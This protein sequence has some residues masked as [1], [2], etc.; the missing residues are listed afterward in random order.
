MTFLVGVPSRLKS[1]IKLVMFLVLLGLFGS[2]TVHAIWI[3][4][5]LLEPAAEHLQVIVRLDDDVGLVVGGRVGG[6]VIHAG[7]WL[8]NGL[9]LDTDE[10]VV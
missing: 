2:S 6:R 10:L 1:V 4:I 7:R 3:R 5:A 8:V 9:P